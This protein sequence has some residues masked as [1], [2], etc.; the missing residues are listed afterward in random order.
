MRVTSADALIPCFYLIME[1][2]EIPSDT[3]CWPSGCFETSGMAYVA[4][5]ENIV[6]CFTIITIYDACT[7]VT[8]S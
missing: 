1:A 8:R 3:R 7:T 6:S 4:Q 5:I 2:S